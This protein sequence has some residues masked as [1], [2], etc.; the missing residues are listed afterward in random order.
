[1]NGLLRN[2]RRKALAQVFKTAA[3]PEW[4]E[5]ARNLRRADARDEMIAR[6]MACQN[7]L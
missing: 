3:E 7:T 1:V 2:N 4:E 5:L 6:Q